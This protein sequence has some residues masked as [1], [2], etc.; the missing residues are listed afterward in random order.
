MHGLCLPLYNLKLEPY[1]TEPCGASVATSY[2][3][4]K[5]NKDKTFSQH[6]FVLHLE[7]SVSQVPVHV[8]RQEGNE[9]P[10]LW[11][12]GLGCWPQRWNPSSPR[13]TGEETDVG[14]A[15][16]T[17][18]HR[19]GGKCGMCVNVCAPGACVHAG[20][21]SVEATKIKEAHK[22]R[23]MPKAFTTVWFILVQV[24]SPGQEDS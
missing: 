14:R 8:D 12:V 15:Q 24:V 16:I 1:W 5:G 9:V 23:P 4:A 17:Q 18:S 3:T 10:E 21:G 13:V 7:D 22:C 11:A 2:H 6:L 20:V 19:A